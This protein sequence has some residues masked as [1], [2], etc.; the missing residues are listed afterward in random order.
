MFRCWCSL[1][2]ARGPTSDRGRDR[3]HRRS[4]VL[5]QAF[6]LPVSRDHGGPR[7]CFPSVDW[8][9]PSADFEGG[10][11]HLEDQ[12]T[13]IEGATPALTPVHAL[14]RCADEL[15]ASRGYGRNQIEERPA[16]PALTAAVGDCMTEAGLGADRITLKVLE[17]GETGQIHIET[18]H[19]LPE[20]GLKP[21][22]QALSSCMISHLEPAP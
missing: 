8:V 14:D 13:P 17:N 3:Y 5:L 2:S 6:G 22:Q 12:I 16:P 7:P 10:K 18:E 21:F 19:S 15:A 4:S 11:W 20:S 9:W 1:V